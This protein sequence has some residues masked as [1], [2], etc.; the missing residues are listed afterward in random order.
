MPTP[1]V[2]EL[3]MMMEGSFSTSIGRGD[4]A[5]TKIENA[6]AASFLPLL[7][8]SV[9]RVAPI[10]AMLLAVHRGS[11]R[12]LLYAS[13]QT[14]GGSNDRASERRSVS[15]AKSVKYRF[16]QHLLSFATHLLCC[17]R[18]SKKG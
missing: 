1:K 4:T 3:R 5:V 2:E 17:V 11:C 12:F 15:S 7:K 13:S 6:P 14:T 18:G 8:S 10:V 9:L 16:L